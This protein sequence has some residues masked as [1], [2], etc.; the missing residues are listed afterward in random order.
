MLHLI[1]RFY[2]WGK[3]G[4]VNRMDHYELG[5]GGR[6]D[7]L[8]CQKMARAYCNSVSL[9]APLTGCARLTTLN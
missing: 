6:P 8:P 4:A 7:R 2:L 5:E 9:G 1:R 3:T